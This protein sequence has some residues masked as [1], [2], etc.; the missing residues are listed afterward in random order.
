MERL[1]LEQDVLIARHDNHEL[2]DMELAQMLSDIDEQLFLTSNSIGD[3]RRDQ[4]GDKLSVR[5]KIG[6][7]FFGR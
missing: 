7:F 5:R 3:I 6:H 4:R 2:T 1:K